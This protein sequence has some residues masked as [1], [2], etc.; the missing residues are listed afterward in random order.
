MRPFLMV[1]KMLIMRGNLQI[2]KSDLAKNFF[3]QNICIN[4]KFVVIL[5]TFSLQ[6]EKCKTKPQI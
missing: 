5:H 1:C 6:P 3:C 2:V 4:E